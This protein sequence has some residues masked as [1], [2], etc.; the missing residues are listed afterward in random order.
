VYDKDNKDI[1]KVFSL[2]EKL[3]KEFGVTPEEIDYNAIFDIMMANGQVHKKIHDMAEKRGLLKELLHAGENIMEDVSTEERG[4]ADAGFRFF[5]EFY[6]E[7]ER[8]SIKNGGNETAAFDKV[9]IAEHNRLTAGTGGY[10]MYNKYLLEKLDEVKIKYRDEARKRVRAF[11]ASA[12]KFKETETPMSYIADLSGDDL[13][14]AYAV[15]RIG[16]LDKAEKAL[17]AALN[18]EFDASAYEDVI[19]MEKLAHAYASKI[20]R[21]NKAIETAGDWRKIIRCEIDEK[22][23]VKDHVPGWIANLGVAVNDEGS[24]HDIEALRSRI[25]ENKRLL[26]IEITEND[27]ISAKI[28]NTDPKLAVRIEKI[29]TDEKGKSSE[30]A[31]MAISKTSQVVPSGFENGYR[32]VGEERSKT[33]INFEQ[34]KRGIAYKFQR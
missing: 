17:C 22:S 33:K 9:W 14:A 13:T 27:T 26:A 1:E 4:K 7:I 32:V 23:R 2:K 21:D 25:S 18:C 6:R 19:K 24:V 16:Q 12:A 31:E 5:D 34:I 28:K 30:S 8:E 15:N 3:E 11:N 29:A 10:F 20:K